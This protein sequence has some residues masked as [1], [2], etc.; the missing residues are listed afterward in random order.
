MLCNYIK[1]TRATTWRHWPKW[2]S[3]NAQPGE[4][5]PLSQDCDTTHPVTMACRVHVS[6]E[7][8]HAQSLGRPRRPPERREVEGKCCHV[9][10][11]DFGLQDAF[12]NYQIK[13]RFLKGASAFHFSSLKGDTLFTDITCIT[14]EL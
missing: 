10:T 2:P 5:T 9:W 7:K 6:A 3:V 1:Q 12:Y 14:L 13:L 8:P 11:D 4:Q